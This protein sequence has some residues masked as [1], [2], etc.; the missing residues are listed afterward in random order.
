MASQPVNDLFLFVS[1][2]HAVAPFNI[3]YDWRITTTASYFPMMYL[4]PP[5]TA[6]P[7]GIA[8]L[9]AAVAS[10]TTV[11]TA[12]SDTPVHFA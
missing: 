1:G 12:S 9:A 7:V 8:R 4:G 2:A 5:T 3:Y 6:T 11:L 10:P